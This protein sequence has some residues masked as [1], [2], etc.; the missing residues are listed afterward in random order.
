MNLIAFHRAIVIDIVLA[1]GAKKLQ[2]LCQSS[3]PKTKVVPTTNAVLTTINLVN[4]E[5]PENPAP[6]PFS[7]SAPPD[8]QTVLD[9]VFERVNAGFEIMSGQ[10][11]EQQAKISRLATSVED[12]SNKMN[13][14]Q[15]KVDGLVDSIRRMCCGSKNG[16]PL[17][18][19]DETFI[20]KVHFYSDEE[21]VYIKCIILWHYITQFFVSDFLLGL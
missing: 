2:K 13:D 21:K 17:L 20:K 15:F 16:T 7:F 11:N 1:A 3:T 8:W 18:N 5:N 14:M 6:A 10:F 12:Q 9:R 19:L 4:Q